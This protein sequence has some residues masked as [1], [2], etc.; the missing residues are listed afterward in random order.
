MEEITLKAKRKERSGKTAA[1]ALRHEGYIPAE[2]YGKGGNLSVALKIGDTRVLKQHHYSANVVVNLDVDGEAKP[3]PTIL[4]DYQIHPLTDTLIHLD[5]LR[6]SLTEKV[7][8]EIPVEL[9]G[10]ARGVKLGGLMDQHLFHLTVDCL[11]QDMPEAIEVDVS[12]VDIANSLH[13]SDLKI[14][15]TLHVVNDPGETIVTVAQAES[16]EIAEGAVAE[17]TQPEV[18]KKKKE[19]QA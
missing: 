11:P 10:E 6:I 17:A 2:I 15:D 3:I 12:E 8:V 13:V 4:K 1:R 7:R 9:K 14:A 5:F 18:Q 19:E 16:E